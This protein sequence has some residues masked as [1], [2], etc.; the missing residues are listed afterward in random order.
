MR[1]LFCDGFAAIAAKFSRD[2]RR[3]AMVALGAHALHDGYTDL[4]YIMLPIWQAEFGLTYAALGLLRGAFVGA[5]A[6]LQIPT[7][8]LAERFGAGAVLGLG[9]LLAGLGYCFA[10]ASTGCQHAAPDRI[11]TDGARLHWTALAHGARHL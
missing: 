7:G 3:A 2:E 1:R 10:G 5:M 4:I 9:T 11:R 8:L 6:S